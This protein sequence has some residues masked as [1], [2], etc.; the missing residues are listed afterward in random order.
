M[1]TGALLVLTTLGSADAARTLVRGLVEER[2]I[3]CGTVLP[4]GQSIY[5]WRGSVTEESEVV[6]LLKTRVER[7]DAL[8]AAVT[9][10][11]PYQ[12]P[13]LLAFPVE[14]GL[15]AYLDWLWLETET[16]RAR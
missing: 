11:H 10:R 3:A 12:V 15:E 5:R 14:H 8:R 4:A 7:W 13:E 9:A 6:V 1:P 16:E 2:L